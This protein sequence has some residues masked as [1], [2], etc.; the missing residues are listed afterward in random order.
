MNPALAISPSKQSGPKNLKPNWKSELTARPELIL[1]VCVLVILNGPAL[2]GSSWISMTFEKKSVL[3]GEWWRLFTHP[4]IHVSWYH[5]LLDAT[6]FLTLYAGLLEKNLFRRLSYAVAGAAGS[7]ILAC[8]SLTKPDQT[9]C[10]L[11]GIA[12]GLMAVS[13]LE[14]ILDA[15][16]DA[17]TRRV[18]WLSLILVLGKAMFEAFTGKMFFHFLEFGLLGQPVAISHLGGIVG[19]VTVW[20]LFKT[21]PGG[22]ES[23]GHFG[24]GVKPG[25]KIRESTGNSMVPCERGTIGSEHS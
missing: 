2:F 7:L 19:S 6:A 17:T 21:F 3:Q 20:F 8:T 4:F 9:L 5:L 13:A 16:G 12:H 10:G 15:S 22:T 14:M 23:C 25:L 11:S 24:R 18:G 1:F